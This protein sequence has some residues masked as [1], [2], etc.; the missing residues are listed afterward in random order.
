MH[1]WRGV[2]PRATVLATAIVGVALLLGSF[3]LT[4]VLNARLLASLDSTLLVQ[5]RDRAGL[6]A[7]GADPA[8]LLDVQQREAFVVIETGDTTHTTPGVE[9]IDPCPTSDP[10]ETTAVFV[11]DDA[12]TIERE[13]HRVRMVTA[14]VTTG[15]SGPTVVR[16]AAE[17]EEE[18]GTAAN[19]FS[20]ALAGIPL[21]MALVAWLTWSRVGRALQPVDRIR[22]EAESISG[23]ALGRRVPEPGTGD[24][25]D[26]LA[27]TVN[28]MLDRIAHD[29]QTRRQFASDASHELKSPLANVRAVMDTAELAGDEWDRVHRA[30]DRELVRMATLVDDLLFLATSDEG[31]SRRI[32]PVVIHLDDILFDVAA[33]V[34]RVSGVVVDPGGVAPADVEGD[35]AMIRRLFQ[36]IVENSARYATTRVAITV[37]STSE[38]VVVHV[39]DDGAGI[40]PDRRGDV[41]DRFTRLDEARDRQSGNTGLGLAIARSIVLAH[42]GE[43][44]VEDAPLGGARFT[45]RLPRP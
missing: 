4:A 38:Q 20:A 43:I 41:F 25:I 17:F 35:A 6:V 19:V 16:V 7:A 33:S 44:A 31:G 36:N 34:D 18:R 27:G 14:D 29:A 13:I 21:L 15:T 9:E 5:A 12:G 2:R 23:S 24:E 8:E 42:A 22:R 37:D 1:R 26:R 3:G 45:I 10:C 40:P 28:E 11:E 30:A 39:D 32:D